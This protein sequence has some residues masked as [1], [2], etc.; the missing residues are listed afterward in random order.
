MRR[1]GEETKAWGVPSIDVKR[2]D[3]FP[4]PVVVSIFFCSDDLSND[5]P[6]YRGQQW[7]AIGLGNWAVRTQHEHTT[8]FSIRHTMRDAALPLSFWMFFSLIEC[9]LV[10]FPLKPYNISQ[11]CANCCAA[12]RCEK[13]MFM[14]TFASAVQLLSDKF[15]HVCVARFL[16][17]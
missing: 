7:A 9:Y 10:I 16:S 8:R 13:S 1:W 2:N 4:S 12:A 14:K 15:G 6:P 11:L 3:L 5:T 17:A